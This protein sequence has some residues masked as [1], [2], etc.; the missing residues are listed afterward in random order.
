MGFRV[1]VHRD[2]NP[3]CEVGLGNSSHDPL[4]ALGRSLVVNGALEHSGLDAGPGDALGD[5][6]NEEVDHG[7][8]DVDTEHF[9]NCRSTV[10]EEE[11]HRVVGVAASGH[12]DVEIRH[13]CSD[14][15]NA[16]EVATEAHHRWVDDGRDSRSNERRQLGNGVVDPSVFVAP[17]FGVVLLHIWRE[18]ED[19]L[20]HQGSAEV[21]YSNGSSSGCDVHHGSSLSAAPRLG[22]RHLAC[23]APSSLVASH[24]DQHHD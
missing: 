20:V 2:G 16:R 21:T 7:V 10:V 13:A 11:W 17:L 12:D 5:V 8:G 3:S 15:G 22:G 19:V 23:S 6:A 9:A 24:S 4:D 1:G 14:C 18:H